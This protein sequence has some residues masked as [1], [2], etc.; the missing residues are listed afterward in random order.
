MWRLGS[1]I[2][3]ATDRRVRFDLC[4]HK[5]ELI[6]VIVLVP[7]V[8]A[9]HYAKAHDG[10]IYLAECLIIPFVRNVLGYCS[11]DTSISLRG[12]NLMFKCVV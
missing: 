11:E 2:Q 12:S 3:H 1:R 10:V 4:A 9:L 7:V 6:V 8:F 5:E